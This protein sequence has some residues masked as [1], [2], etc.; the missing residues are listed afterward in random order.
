MAL[1]WFSLVLEPSVAVKQSA[2]EFAHSGRT[3]NRKEGSGHSF[4]SYCLAT[5]LKQS[6]SSVAIAGCLQACLVFFFLPSGGHWGRGQGWR[7]TGSLWFSLIF[8]SAWWQVYTLTLRY[9][10]P[11]SKVKGESEWWECID[12]GSGLAIYWAFSMDVLWKQEGVN[13]FYH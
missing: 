9:P 13:I 12:F 7:K 2:I 5:Q 10:F 11:Y 3:L 1:C 4:W 8:D 6:N